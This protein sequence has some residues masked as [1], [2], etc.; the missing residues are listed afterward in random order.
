MLGDNI[1]VYRL[2][3]GYSQAAFA[4]LLGVSPSTIWLLEHR[5]KLPSL[6]LCVKLASMLGQTIDELL[7]LEPS[8]GNTALECL[9]MIRPDGSI[10][11]ER[12]GVLNT[13]IDAVIQH[14]R[15]AEE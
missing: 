10:D 7:G 11:E 6:R 2:C 13:I 12:L 8:A 15:E 14:R 1:R 9:N 3:A 4:K 5:K